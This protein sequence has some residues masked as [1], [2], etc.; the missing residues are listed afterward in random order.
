[1]SEFIT[2]QTEVRNNLIMQVREVIDFAEAEGRGLDSEE[3]RK[4]EAIEADIAKG[5]GGSVHPLQ[6]LRGEHDVDVHVASVG[7]GYRA[8]RRRRDLLDQERATRTT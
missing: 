1:M 8:T 5:L 6:R 7:R 2:R 4:I 3:L